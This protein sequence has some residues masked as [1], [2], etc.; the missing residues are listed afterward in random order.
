LRPALLLL[1]LLMLHEA[2]ILIVLLHRALLL[3]EVLRLALQLRLSLLLLSAPSRWPVPRTAHRVVFGLQRRTC[4]VCRRSR[5]LLLDR[6][7]APAR[8][9]FVCRRCHGRCYGSAPG[10][11]PG[12]PLRLA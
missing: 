10:S 1:F 12:N 8:R 3:L 7:S 5:G 6:P 11:A 2:L 9:C 4:V